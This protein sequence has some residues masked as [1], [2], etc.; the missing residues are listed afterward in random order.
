MPSLLPP[1]ECDREPHTILEEPSPWPSS[2]AGE[3][4]P[5]C[6]RIWNL[7]IAPLSMAQ[8]LEEIDRRVC[9]RVPGYVVT[10]NLN[11]AMLCSGNERLRRVNEQAA[12]VLADGMPLVWVARWCRRRIPERVT[13]A[14]LL[15]AVCAQ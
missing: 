9:T 10:A 4:H 5:E 1:V 12:L 11:Y 15:P 14:D 13:G 2:G 3:R 8:A 6:V 7:P